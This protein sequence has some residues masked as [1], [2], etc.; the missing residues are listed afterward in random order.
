MSGLEQEELD[1]FNSKLDEDNFKK[2]VD[3]ETN[4]MVPIESNIGQQVVKNYIECLK[5]GAD[6]PHIVSTKMFYKQSTT[7]SGNSQGDPRGEC[8]VCKVMVYSNQERVKMSGGYYH[9]KCSSSLKNSSSVQTS[10]VSNKAPSPA[11]NQNSTK[12]GV[13]KG[14]CGGCKNNVYS[15][16]ERVNHGGLY[17][18]ENCLGKSSTQTSIVST[19]NMGSVKGQCGGCRKTVYSTEQR[20]NKSG[21]Y[22]HEKCQK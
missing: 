21:V 13:V 7:S 15:T 1:Y 11:S 9:E 14:Q 16:Q 20:V 6:S 8:D 3:P 19:K 2:I 4:Q 18:H 12:S 17:F 22:F 5:N 10:M